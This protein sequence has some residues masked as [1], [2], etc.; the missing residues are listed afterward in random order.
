[1][2]AVFAATWAPV[3]TFQPVSGFALAAVAMPATMTAAA[4]VD[5]TIRAKIRAFRMVVLLR[6][7]EILVMRTSLAGAHR[8]WQVIMGS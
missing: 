2:S 6:S 7:P 8:Y 4:S 5:A 3:S 1:V